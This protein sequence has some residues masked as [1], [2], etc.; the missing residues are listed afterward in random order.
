MSG[1]PSLSLRE[2]I[3]LEELQSI[4]DSFARAA[5]ISSVIL[6]PE[7]YPLT[8]FTNPTGFCALIQSTEKGK[9]R[10]F[11]SCM[12]MGEIALVSK[13][14]EI[15]YCFVHGG[16]FVAPII[17]DGEHKGTM[18]AGQF[19]PEKFSSEQQ[20][21]LEKI[22]PDIGIDPMALVK[23]ARKM[24]VI[25]ED[26]IRNYSSLLFKIVETIAKRGV[27]A[28]ELIQVNDAL[29]TAHKALELRF[30]DVAGAMSDW[31]W[32]ADA[33]ARYIYCSEKVKDV[34]GYTAEEMIGKTPFDL[35]MPDEMSGVGGEFAEIVRERRTFRN[36]EN[37]LRTRDGR[38]VC[39]LTSGGPILGDAGEFLGYRGVDSDITERKKAEKALK[40]RVEFE[41]IITAISTSFINL[42]PDE[43]DAGIEDALRSIG[44]F[45]GVDRSYL[46]QFFNN[47]M[48]ADN[49][50]EWCAE[51]I[52]SQ[53]ENLKGLQ[54]ANFQYVLDRFNR[55]E[56]VHIP[57]VANLPPEA[58]SEKEILQS[59]NI[60][61]VLLV[62]IAHG[63][64]LIGYLG[65]DSMR[66]AQSWSE[67]SISLLRIV[68]EIFASALERRRVMG[69]IK[70]SEEKYRLL[71]DNTADCIWQMNLD[72]E[73]TYVNPSVLQMFGFTPD[74]W[75]GSSLFKHCSPEDME[76]VSGLA[77][78]LLKKGPGLSNTTFEMQVLHK[79]GK[80]ITTEID[81][82]ILFDKDEN[83]VGIQGSMRDITERKR[84]AENLRKKQD[85]EEAYTDILTVTNSTIDLNTIVTGGLSNLMKYTDSRLGVVYLYNRDR[86]ALLPMVARGA[87]D[88]VAEQSFLCGEGIPGETAAKKA[89]V[90]VTDLRDTIYKIPSGD[91]TVPPDTIISTPVIFKDTLLGV[92]ITCYTKGATPELMDFTK[93]VTEQIAVA[94]NNANTYR[95]TQ[96]MA[97]ELKSEHD[98]LKITSL[99]LAAA[100][101]TKSELLA[102]MSHELRTPLNSI[103]G[104]SEI[105]H[106]EVFGPVNEKQAKYVNNV[107]VSGKHLLQLINDILDFSKVE[108][109][110]MELVCEDFYVSD[111]IN[112]V[113][114]LTA[115]IA[116]KKRLVVD[117]SVDEGLPLIHADEGK[118]KQ[119][120]Y[121]LLSNAI[122][123]TPEHGLV[124]V[125]ARQSA[126]VVE[127]AVTDTGIGISEA[128]QKKLFQPFVQAD[129]TTSKEYGGT[130]LGLSLVKKF[131]ELHGG[132]AW[133]ES[134]IGTGSTFTFTIPIGCRA[135][136]ET[137]TETAEEDMLGEEVEPEVEVAAETEMPEKMHE[138]PA[139]VDAMSA[140]EIAAT[141]LPAIIEP[142]GASGDEPLI[143]VVEDDENSSELLTVTLTG[144]GYRV[145]PVYNGRKA[146][147]VAKRLKPFA[148]TLD[149]M[150]PGM[151]GWDVLKY[152]KY[153]SETSDIPVIVV[154]ML[155]AAEVGFSLGVVDYFVKP[156]E[157]RTLI[158]A[159]NTLK[160]ALGI[161]MPKVLV[162]DDDPDAVE[163]VASMIEP[164]GFEV[165]RAYGGEEGVQKSVSEHPNVL[166]LDLM[167]PEVSG[168]DVVA[169]LKI[170]PE[171]RN[172]PIII[173]TSKDPTSEDVLQLRSDV[174][175]V[176]QKGEFASEGLVNE[177]IKV[178]TLEGG[179]IE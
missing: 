164:A 119:I 82:K 127:I 21:T 117:V 175:S 69:A 176:M 2:L 65:F 74:E 41:K 158:A 33:D 52:L 3:D 169:R 72:F 85:A 115:S 141:R 81:Y 64:A 122:K 140:E 53:I 174:I 179:R 20:K 106:D 170:E 89:T 14:P 113:R 103:I 128:D 26:V 108:A 135:E 79:N 48:T 34:L 136:A 166:I 168:F 8:K 78:E 59:Q 15:F 70:D 172:I 116:A 173:C 23:E 4:Q 165:I 155:D 126:D 73:F 67:D 94:I 6:S 88:A 71:A 93:R 76:F 62:P 97:A 92:V 153:D 150:L 45:A 86:K 156:V 16:N 143:L 28:A 160:D 56:A 46:F 60:R 9:E 22:A 63:G 24:R 102:N 50:H 55:S 154:S 148:I 100:S 29:E 162:V 17:I 105:L 58:R 44:E 145:I 111:A 99:E 125:G 36:M 39:M 161:D 138:V 130:G 51:G 47:G 163:L 124:T 131:S 144:A 96:E 118:V 32:E 57:S 134:E 66:H 109:G 42:A 7:G 110:K 159:L 80:T 43:I 84:I 27:Q 177:I 151:D 87:E 101:K 25:G 49:T 19:I 95:E 68:G 129:A 91:G 83:P 178:T 37:R 120:L 31:V 114:T 147:A 61:S 121:N 146:L 38:S 13:K 1:S 18:F 133:V 171:T 139:V 142:E 157:K 77:K 40:D 30:R 107:L 167:M 5:G 98:K 12:G 75:I 11:R 152:L 132:T 149:I 10:C 112:E 90:V 104:F 54:T 137:E 35:M 123:F